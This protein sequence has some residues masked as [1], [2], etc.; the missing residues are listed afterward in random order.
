MDINQYIDQ[1]CETDDVDELNAL[2]KNN[3]VILATYVKRTVDD[4]IYENLWYSVGRVNMNREF[5]K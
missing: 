5:S 3:G 2:L 4:V 1:V